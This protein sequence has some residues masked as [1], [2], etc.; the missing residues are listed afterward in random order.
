METRA[1]VSHVPVDQEG[2]GEGAS[3][4]TGFAIRHTGLPAGAYDAEPG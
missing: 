1:E 4:G 3:S 2:P